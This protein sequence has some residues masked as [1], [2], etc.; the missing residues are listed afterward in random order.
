MGSSCGE[1]DGCDYQQQRG[2]AGTSTV[3]SV[4]RVHSVS[5]ASIAE[6]K[7][8]ANDREQR[9]GKILLLVGSLSV[10]FDEVLGVCPP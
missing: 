8:A 3:W 6:A 5:G 10:G 7:H 1:R 2:A 4:F 9:M